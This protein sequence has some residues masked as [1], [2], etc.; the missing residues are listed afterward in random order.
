MRILIVDDERDIQGLLAFIL[1]KAGYPD[2]LTARSARE[3]FTQLGMDDPACDVSPV[4]L[5][6]MDVTMGEIDG[7]EA[8]RRIKARS[9]LEDLPIIMITGRTEA[10]LLMVA[11]DAGAMD[12][13]TKPLNKV[14]L[15]ARVRSALH[16]KHEMDRRKAR[17]Q[18]LLRV[19]QQLAA[20]NEQLAQLAAVD[21]LTG[22]ANRRQFDKVLHQEW[23]TAIQAATSMSL[24]LVDVDH[25]KAFNDTYGHPHGDSCLQRVAGAL[26]HAA[27]RPRDL[28]ARYGGEEFVIL[29]PNTD[30][31]G[32]AVVAERVRD[33]VA[34]QAIAHARS[35]VGPCVTVSMG[36][37]AARLRPD[38]QPEALVA[39]ADQALYQAKQAGRNRVSVAAPL[40]EVV[41]LQTHPGAS[42]TV[43]LA[44]VTELCDV[45]A[46]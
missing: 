3:A 34:A 20:A 26:V 17:E 1:K 45:G 44:D 38:L 21:G 14:E 4:D 13:I 43:F 25:F 39:A 11:F 2:V 8:C 6:L 29:L 30:L 27:S 31:G 19:T 40:D 42:S 35:S 7:I 33:A 22:I 36:V 46:A 41:A 37:A 15:L 16:L 12:Y 23:G 10:E 9:Y 32:A 18:E 28:V 24:I 5:L